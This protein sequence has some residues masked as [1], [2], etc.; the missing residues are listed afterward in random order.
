[1]RVVVA[2]AS[3]F[4]GTALRVQL[5]AHGHDVVTLVRSGGGSATQSLWDP[6]AGKVDDALISSADA[7]VNLAGAPIAHWPWTNSYR[8]T[9]L[10]SRVSTTATL[11]GAIARAATPPAL[12]V[13]SGMAIY[14]PD[15]GSEE[16][17]ESSV[18]GAG[19]LADV[20]RQWEAAADPARTAGARVCHLRTGVVIDGRGGALK[21]MLPA[22]RL[23]LAGRLGSGRQYF[24]V[25]SLAD[26]VAAA[27][28]L[29]EHPECEGPYDLVGLEPPTNAQFTAALAKALHRPAV[30]RVPALPLRLVLGQ[31]SADLLGSLRVRPTRLVEAGFEH[32]HRDVDAIVAAA[33]AD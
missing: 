12:V 11:A 1:M 28:F 9:I 16:L 26:W 29:V 19:F 10:A 17:D 27:T 13:A 25:I 2:G 21:L 20:V 8:D 22:F 5:R 14:G 24:S 15:R 18:H 31:L 33:L 3:G 4:L 23:G 30:L 6:Y 7:V 32:R